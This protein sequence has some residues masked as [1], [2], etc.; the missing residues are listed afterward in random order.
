MEE[1]EV[2]EL[3]VVSSQKEEEDLAPVH[4]SGTEEGEEITLKEIL[5]FF[6]PFYKAKP[7]VSLVGGLANNGKTKDDIDIFIRST[8]EDIATEFRIFRMFPE[9]Y[10]NR[11]HI[12]YPKTDDDC[13]G[14]YTNYI[15]LFDLKLESISKKHVELMSAIDERKGIKL[16]TF[17][18]LLKPQ[19]GRFKGELYTV[20][21]LI[22]LVNKKP[23]WYE[24]KIAV[25]RKYDG[26]HCR[27]DCKGE[28]VKIY[29]EEGNEIT[30]KCPTIASEFKEICKGHD[31]VVTGE[32][33]SWENK[34]HMARQLTTGIIHSKGIH[35][36]EKTLKLFIFDCLYYE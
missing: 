15:D 27:V 16:F 33:E 29:T 25:Q 18:K 36:K 9:K 3:P 22:E 5:P 19:H 32:L 20:D 23:E 11:I 21:S 17:S 26:I 2:P 31:V 30:D 13:Y 24:K 8:K 14:V 10:R 34:K 6:K 4:P 12:L 7:Y 1:N 28:T 35:E